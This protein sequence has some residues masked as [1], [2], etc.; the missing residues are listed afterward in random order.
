[1]WT[2][3]VTKVLNYNSV[4]HL[5]LIHYSEEVQC[6]VRSDQE[7]V[8]SSEKVPQIIAIWRCMFINAA[9]S[10]SRGGGCLDGSDTVMFMW[11]RGARFL[12]VLKSKSDSN[13]H[14]PATRKNE[15]RKDDLSNTSLPF[16]LPGLHLLF[17][18]MFFFGKV[19]KRV[20][21]RGRRRAQ[22][23]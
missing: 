3:P 18:R 5:V 16:S 12:C 17:Q 13:I 10:C 1:M 8:K 2:P 7:K 9:G 11:Y 14:K 22:T 23:G 19:F 4:V 6:T 15:S 21:E 20:K